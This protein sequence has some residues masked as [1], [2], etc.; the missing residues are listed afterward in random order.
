VGRD[1]LILKQI[2]RVAQKIVHSENF[3][4]MPLDLDEYE[5]SFELATIEAED[6]YQFINPHPH[7]RAEQQPDEATTE[8]FIRLIAAQKAQIRELEGTLRMLT[9][10]DQQVGWK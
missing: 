4:D 3:P 10:G 6:D 9:M 7:T 5:D 2:D 8:E 1:S